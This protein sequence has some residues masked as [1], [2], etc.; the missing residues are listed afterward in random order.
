MKT[1]KVEFV[2]IKKQYASVTVNADNKKAAIDI[3][4]KMNQEDFEESESREANEWKAKT[5][6]NF[7]HLLGIGK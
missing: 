2:T 4:R 3:A 6:W 1:Y 5:E 7:L